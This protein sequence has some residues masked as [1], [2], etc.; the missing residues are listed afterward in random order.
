MRYFFITTWNKK[1][2][3]VMLTVTFDKVRMLSRPYENRQ[4]PCLL[5]FL[6]VIFITLCFRGVIITVTILL[7]GMC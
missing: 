3:S 2:M 1:L 5:C 4:H 7:L 6:Q